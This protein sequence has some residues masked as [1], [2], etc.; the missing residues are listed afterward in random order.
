[1]KPLFE[2]E[3]NW[4]RMER[5]LLSWLDTPYRHL[6][7]VKGRGAD[8]TLFVAQ[9]MVNVGF[10]LKVEYDYYSRDWHIHTKEEFVLKSLEVHIKNNLPE[11]ITA[12]DLSNSDKLMRGDLILYSTTKKNVTNHCAILLDEFDGRCQVTIHSI[13]RRGVSRFP[14]GRTWKRKQRGGF[15]FMEI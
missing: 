6:Q 5:E 9:A 7:N 10:L 3:D 2:R 4:K 1:M 12:I 15:R 8:C 13:N 14:L 11:N